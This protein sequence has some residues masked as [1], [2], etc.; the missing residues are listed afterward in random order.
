MK[1]AP[2]L[3]RFDVRP[4]RSDDLSD[5]NLPEGF[6]HG[7]HGLSHGQRLHHIACRKEPK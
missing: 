2:R 1:N 6:F 5:R 3:R 4:R 7:G